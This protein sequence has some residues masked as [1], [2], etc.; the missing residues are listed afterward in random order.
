MF[1]SLLARIFLSRDI[2]AYGKAME[3]NDR[4]FDG[5]LERN[6]SPSEMDA[7]TH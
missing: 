4:P 6:Y 2:L 7:K 3:E 5:R 1:S